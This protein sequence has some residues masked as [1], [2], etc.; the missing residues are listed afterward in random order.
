MFDTLNP[1]QN[2]AFEHILQAKSADFGI[3]AAIITAFF[4]A[5]HIPCPMPLLKAKI[6][7]RSVPDSEGLYLLASDKNSQH[8]LVAFCQKN[9]HTVHSWVDDIDGESVYQFF[10]IKA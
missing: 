1:S 4:D 3:D 2:A 7:L 8:D 9:G 10:I 6:T 5:R